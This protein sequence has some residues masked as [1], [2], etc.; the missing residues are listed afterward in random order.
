VKTINTQAVSGKQFSKLFHFPPLFD[1][2]ADRKGQ[3]VV[4][5]TLIFILLLVV[6]WIPADFGLAFYTG[7]IAQ[8]AAREGARIAAADPNLV[9]A[10]A[11]ASCNMPACYTAGNIY[12]ETAARLPAAMITSAQIFLTLD[13]AGAGC[14]RMVTVRVTGN[15]NYTFYKVIR[16]FGI[17]TPNTSVI[18]RSASM[19]WEHQAGC[20][21]L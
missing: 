20:A 6:A 21:S 12:N 17:Q 18:T 19:R 8:N 3:T 16:L 14:N 1:T 7:Q 10:A 13:G 15:Y 4:E 9:A 2:F 11:T 5:F